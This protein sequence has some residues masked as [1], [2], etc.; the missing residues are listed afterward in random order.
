MI[1]NSFTDGG[2]AVEIFS[3]A[4]RIPGVTDGLNHTIGV[5]GF[6]YVFC[7]GGYDLVWLHPVK[8]ALKLCY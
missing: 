3:L 5:M 4:Q 7:C 1:C 6:E 8:I 2:H